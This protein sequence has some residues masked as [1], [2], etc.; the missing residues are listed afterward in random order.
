AG[1][2]ATKAFYGM[3]TGLNFGDGMVAPSMIELLPEFPILIEAGDMK[4]I[5]FVPT[6]RCRRLL[7]FRFDRSY[8]AWVRL[9]QGG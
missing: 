6:H 8:A 9:V 2:P 1:K 3:S 4:G 7:R 5:R